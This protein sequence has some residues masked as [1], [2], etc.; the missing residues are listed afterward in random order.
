[1]GLNKMITA[2]DVPTLEVERLPTVDAEEFTFEE[3]TPP[4]G[5]AK[6]WSK[7]CSKWFNIIVYQNGRIS[8]ADDLDDIIA[9]TEMGSDG[10]FTKWKA[11]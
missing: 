3:K 8:F 11:A 4:N 2:T 5:R 9:A 7:P 10:C 1:M 6:I